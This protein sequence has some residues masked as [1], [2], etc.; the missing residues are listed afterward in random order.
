MGRKIKVML[1]TEGTYPFH[2]GGVSTWSD[3]LI[4]NMKD[5]DYVVLSIMMNPFVTQKFSLPGGVK[6][7]KLPLW[8]TEE[9]GEHLENPFSQV[10]LSKK[11]TTE[12]I[13]KEKFIPQFTSLI[14]GILDD[15]KDF[16]IVG[17]VLVSLYEYFQVYEYK[18]S[19]KSEITWD[20]YKEIVMEYASKDETMASKPSV[21][22]LIQSLGWIYRFMNVLNTPLPQVDVCHSAAAAFCGIPCVVSKLKYNSSFMLTEH[23]VYLREQY[24]SLA[25]RS[26]P[27]YLSDFFIKLIY[28]VTRLNYYYAD[29]I[30]PV[31]RYNTKWERE[32]GTDINKIKVIYNGVD[33]KIFSP[34]EKKRE[35]DEIRVVTVARIDPVKDIET[36]IQAAD[37]VIKD[38]ENINFFVYGSISVPEYYEKC[39][40]LVNKLGI[41]E[42]FHMEG[43][44]SDV[45][46]AYASG[47]I[48][49]LSSISE[50]FPY[51]VVEAMMC[52]RP[53]VATDVGGISE[54]IGDAGILVSP[55]DHKE[56]SN[57]II[58]LIDDS[59]LR[60]KMGMEGRELAINNFS[61]KRMLDN[62]MKSYINLSLK[63]QM[64]ED[65]AL[66]A[67][68]KVIALLELA[69]VLYASGFYEDSI[70]KMREVIK[71]SPNKAI[72]PY[73]L[74]QISS[75]YKMLG[76]E[77]SSKNE[78]EK[79]LVYEKLVNSIRSA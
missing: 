52:G 13:I 11:R 50:G 72:V 74:S 39:K 54:A 33:P 46:G 26:Y 31:C 75:A 38:R 61:I 42:R 15:K 35:T 62:H 8:G 28:F 77:K 20:V 69:D 44:I 65:K 34:S 51:S 9:P 49:V 41:Q 78:A 57:A 2:Q 48:I 18:E 55:K 53:V 76:D 67:N 6:L 47:D 70:K 4:K 30:S 22:S 45:P 58:K 5:I 32:L 12:E 79:A 56:M 29:Q 66:A 36:L 68:R 3:T 10:Y 24:L 71:E 16:D 40:E 14:R 7:I 19:F 64:Q 37:V 59:E 63:T 43:H 23:G 25:N 17:K 73:L 1:S 27:S 60:E 21:F